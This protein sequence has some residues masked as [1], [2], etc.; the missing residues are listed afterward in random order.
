MYRL[1]YWA[2][3]EW[4]EGE[5]LVAH[6]P[7]LPEVTA[8]GRTEKDVLI[9]LAALAASHVRQLLDDGRPPPDPSP[10]SEIAGTIRSKELSRALISVEV[11]RAIARPSAR[12]S[13][14]VRSIG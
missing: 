5:V 1:W 6:L 4:G 3:I 9:N 10:A 8:A 14:A 13:G 7:D 11:P 12:Y 2:L